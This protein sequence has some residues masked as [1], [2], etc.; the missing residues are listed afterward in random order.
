MVNNSSNSMFTN[1]NLQQ[2]GDSIRNQRL[3]DSLFKPL[4]IKPNSTS[5]N[6]PDVNNDV[7]R[8]LIGIN[9]FILEE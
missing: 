8:E 5:T 4:M 1:P 6:P 9:D 3:P 7:S 2:P